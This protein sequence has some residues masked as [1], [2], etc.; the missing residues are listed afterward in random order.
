MQ[1]RSFGLLF[2]RRQGKLRALRSKWMLALAIGAAGSAAYAG[3]V[4]ATPSSGLSTTILAESQFN[5]FFAQ[6]H[7]FPPAWGAL[8][9][10]YGSTDAYVVDN[11][12]D[13][14]G[15]TGWHSHPGPSLILV[16][17]GQVTNYTSKDRDCAGHV[18][19][20]GQGFIDGGGNDEHTL[21]NNGAT[22]AE[23]I[24][25]QLIPHGAPRKI[26]EPNPTHCPV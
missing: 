7:A 17:S 13:P 26:D 9:A 5:S 1:S 15:T 2:A 19:S 6:A 24:A 20:A 11:K 8:V 4:L 3:D 22:E 25:V 21:R 16:V 18:Y 23:T 10:G 14:G 12:I